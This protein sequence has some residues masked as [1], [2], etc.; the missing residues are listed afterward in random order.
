VE[1]IPQI[2][3]AQFKHLR[4]RRIT[5]AKAAKQY[6]I[7]RR[8]ITRWV[9]NG[10]IKILEAE[11]IGARWPRW[12]LDAADVAYCAGVYQALKERYGDQLRGVRL[13]DED[14]APYRVK[15]PEFA[16]YRRERRQAEARSSKRTRRPAAKSP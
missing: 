12:H 13:F 10:W 3:R 7:H 9:N 11:D 16:Q 4:G 14:G 8:T 6:G 1:D 15:W 2:T 5:V